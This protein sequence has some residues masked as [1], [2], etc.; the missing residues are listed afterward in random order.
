MGNDCPNCNRP[1]IGGKAAVLLTRGTL[2]PLPTVV[3]QCGNVWVDPS[4]QDEMSGVWD[5]IREMID[6]EGNTIL[7]IDD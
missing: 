2:E 6:G 5:D 7:A 4:R 3:C 1:A